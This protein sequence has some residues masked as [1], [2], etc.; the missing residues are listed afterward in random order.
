MKR[1][2]R[3]LHTTNKYVGTNYNGFLLWTTSLKIVQPHNIIPAQLL[4]EQINLKYQTLIGTDHGLLFAASAPGMGVCPEPAIIF[5][6]MA[7][8]YSVSI[9]G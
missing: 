8:Y 3:N 5:G 9:I 2:E 7:V 6:N 4:L 1:L